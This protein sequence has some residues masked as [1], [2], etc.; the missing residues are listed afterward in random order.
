[1]KKIRKSLMLVGLSLLLGACGT[2]PQ[3]SDSSNGDN[4]SITTYYTIA[5]NVNDKRYATARV[6]EGEKITQKITDPAPEDGY[7]FSGW[8]EEGTEELLD[9]ETYVV[10]HDATFNAKFSKIE[11]G[12]E[13]LSVEDEKE[14]GKEYYL[15]LGWWN[16]QQLMMMAHKN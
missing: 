12:G 11:E 3:P 8:Y 4:T 9:F 15:V 14:E 5:F 1:M 6:K 2:K 16:V 10:M 13:V 7:K